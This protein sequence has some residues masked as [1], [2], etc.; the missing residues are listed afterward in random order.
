MSHSH[1]ESKMETQALWDYVPKYYGTYY[2]SG[3]LHKC[4]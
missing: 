2:L 4:R 1:T 3:L